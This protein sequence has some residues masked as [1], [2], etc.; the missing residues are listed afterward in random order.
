MCGCVANAVLRSITIHLTVGSAERKW[1]KLT[2]EEKEICKQYSK[3][4]ENGM[5]HCNECPLV[6]NRTWTLCKANCRA[7]EWR[8]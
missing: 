5:V 7:E 8:T 6:I 2:K 4:D 3:R 1:M